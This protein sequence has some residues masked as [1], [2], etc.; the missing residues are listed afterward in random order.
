MMMLTTMIVISRKSHKVTHYVYGSSYGGCDCVYVYACI[1][2]CTNLVP[3]ASLQ[4]LF[5]SRET[6]FRIFNKLHI[7]TLFLVFVV[8]LRNSQIPSKGIELDVV[9]LMGEPPEKVTF[10]RI[11]FPVFKVAG[12]HNPAQI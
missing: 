12:H 9:C 4:R 11:Y 7:G 10:F 8:A 2:F 3:R 6:C 5:T 1:C